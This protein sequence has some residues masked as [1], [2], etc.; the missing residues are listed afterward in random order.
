MTVEPAENG[1]NGVISHTC[2]VCGD[3]VFDILLPPVAEEPA[4]QA[5]DVDGDGEVTSGDA[6]F[7]LRAS[8][9]LDIL[10]PGTPA[11]LAA[12]AD[13]NGLIESADARLI[14]RISVGL[15]KL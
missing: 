5:G 12:D 14:L 13:G 11:F 8:V 9:G 10:L 7:S 2:S 15:E 4:R 3:T 1:K 6:R